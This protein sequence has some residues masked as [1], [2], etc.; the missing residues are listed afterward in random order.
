MEVIYSDKPEKITWDEYAK[1]TK[2]QKCA[3]TKK[4]NKWKNS[5]SSAQRLDEMR[6]L[7]RKNK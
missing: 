3:A 1:M 6:K 7:L 4:I 2:S 5:L